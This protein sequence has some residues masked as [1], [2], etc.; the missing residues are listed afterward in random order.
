MLQDIAA[1]L[2]VTF[3]KH[4]L[5]T[6]GQGEGVLRA[7]TTGLAFD[8]GFNQSGLEQVAKVTPRRR[9][10]HAE[11][12]GDIL[13]CATTCTSQQVEH[14]AFGGVIESDIHGSVWVGS[15]DSSSVINLT[16]ITP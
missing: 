10:G 8:A 11:G 14:A 12:I 16:Q 15:R 3:R 13:G 5:A 2:C 1:Q 4:R 7:T 6:R 9:D